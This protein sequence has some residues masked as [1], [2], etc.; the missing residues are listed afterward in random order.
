MLLLENLFLMKLAVAREDLPVLIFDLMTLNRFWV[1]FN[2]LLIKYYLTVTV[3][4]LYL[5]LKERVNG[6]HGTKQTEVIKLEE[7]FVGLNS[8]LDTII[9]ILGRIAEHKAS[10]SPLCSTPT[11]P[12]QV[13]KVVCMLPY[14]A[15]KITN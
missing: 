4:C 14:V 10:S 2:A 11:Q 12:K 6:F 5:T 15:I 1:A 8:K 3:I 9:D 13:G 7:L